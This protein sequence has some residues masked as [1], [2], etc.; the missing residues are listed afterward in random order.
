MSTSRSHTCNNDGHCNVVCASLVRMYVRTYLITTERA[1][2][3]PGLPANVCHRFTVKLSYV[4]LSVEKMEMDQSNPVGKTVER[5][6]GILREVYPHSWWQRY[7]VL[8]DRACEPRD[9]AKHRE[10]WDEIDS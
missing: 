7:C 2:S 3:L 5:Q 10:W 8:C 9:A 1:H 6:S 4:Q